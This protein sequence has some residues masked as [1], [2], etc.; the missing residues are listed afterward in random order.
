[1]KRLIGSLLLVGVLL[2]WGCPDTSSHSRGVFMLLDSSGTYKKEL[3][4]SEAIINYLLGT[5]N[6]GDYLAVARIDSGSF[7]E[8]DII[9]KTTFDRR[10]SMTVRQ[11]RQFRKNIDEFMRTAKSS[12]F[13]DIDGGILQAIDYLDEHDAGKKHILIF[14]DLVQDL[15]KGHVR[16]KIP[17]KMPG[18]NVLA[19]NVIKLNKDNIDPRKYYERIEKLRLRIEDGGGKLTVIKDLDRL[20]AI[21]TK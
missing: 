10:P 19:L 15:P 1:M 17:F 14:S 4:Q 21:L 11:K 7:S 20:D 18:Y 13:T 8:K 3:K 9:A 6:P 2:I 5:L 16:E 12:S